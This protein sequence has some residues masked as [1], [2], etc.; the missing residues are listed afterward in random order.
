[1]EEAFQCWGEQRV[2]GYAASLGLCFLGL[3]PLPY[4]PV[5]QERVS[6]S[7]HS[8]RS[9]LSGFDCSEFDSCSLAVCC[10]CS[11]PSSACR[12]PWSA[13]LPGPMQGH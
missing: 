13:L 8:S 6:H 4:S 12:V 11:P 1:M 7:P 5:S 10:A 2:R 3:V 9:L